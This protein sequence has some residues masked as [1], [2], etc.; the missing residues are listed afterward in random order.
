MKRTI[1][2]CALFLAMNAMAYTQS[3][4][5][6][7]A[8]TIWDEARGESFDGRYMVAAVIWNRGDGVASK[9]VAAV[10]KPKQFSGWNGG[11]KPA[12]VIRN[13][14]DRLIWGECKAL[15]KAMLEGNFKPRTE[16]THFHSVKVSPSWSKT[17]RFIKQVGRHKFYA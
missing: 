5:D 4:L 16:A 14:N 7:I 12:V 2:L 13:D 8:S 1:A 6:A 9:M 15:A 10:K 11:S 17:R 3:D